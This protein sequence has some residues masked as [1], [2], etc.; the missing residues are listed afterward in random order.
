[1]LTNEMR[2]SIVS[3]PLGI[4]TFHLE[5]KDEMK[6]PEYK[7]AALRGAFGSVFKRI[8]CALRKETCQDCMLK[9]KCIYVYV[10]ETQPPVGA[11]KL[12]KIDRI[13]S[14]F[15]IEP[16]LEQ[17]MLYHRGEKLEFKLV[18]IGKAL[19]YLPYFIYTFEEVGK[20]GI[21]S[22]WERGMGQFRLL[23]VTECCEGE[24]KVV[25]NG[26]DRTVLN[27]ASGSL[28]AAIEK[29]TK[30]LNSA[31]RA[32]IRFHTPTRIMV[33]EKLIFTPTFQDIFRNLL[34]RL[35][36]LLE[37]HCSIEP[38]WDF[39]K[40]IEHSST[41]DS[42]TSKMGWYDWERYSRRQ[43]RRMSFSGFVGDLEVE[44]DFS[45]FVEF[46]SI[47]EYLH[48]GKNTTFGLGRYEILAETEKQY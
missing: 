34:R 13:A 32:I 16:S 48:V 3:A 33:K 19:Q 5:V 45:P 38:E 27:A 2:S 35:G 6:L 18:L 15:I 7:G 4:F 21:G 11:D 41:I 44:G 24:K 39:R 40:L 30:E 23:E 47:G 46:L 43:D 20:I 36:N 25:F 42:D 1:M 17:K 28:K 22:G 26:N 10:F 37:F 29:R 14:P 9:N 12:R 31:R 8:V